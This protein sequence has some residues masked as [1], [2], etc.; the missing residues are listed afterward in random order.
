M[1][2]SDFLIDNYPIDKAGRKKDVPNDKTHWGKPYLK[3]LIIIVFVVWYSLFLVQKI[4]LSVVDLGR[5]LTNG[6]VVLK[7]VAGNMS[8]LKTNYYSYTNSNYPVINHHWGSGLLFYLFFIVGSFN[9]AHLLF[10]FASVAA[11]YLFFEIAIKAG[12]F[13]IAAVLSIL[14]IPLVGSRIEVRPEVFS[15]LFSGIFTSVLWQY[16]ENQNNWH[17]LLILPIL[18]LF[19]VN[20]HISELSAY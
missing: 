18:E 5:H 14:L 4:D 11:F 9:G 17:P 1:L 16:R 2:F 7:N 13:N 8:T 12:G 6:R 15:L 20:L 10:I 3:I 19:W